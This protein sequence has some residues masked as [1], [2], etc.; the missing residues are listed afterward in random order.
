M[1]KLKN[2]VNEIRTGSI[3]VGKKSIETPCFFATSDFGGGGTNVS[4]LLVYSDLFIKSKSQLLMNYYYLDINSDLT[5]RF[6]TEIIKKLQGFKDINEFIQYVK[7]EYIQA[8]PKK[9]INSYSFDSK[10]KWLPMILLDSGSGNILRGKIKRKEVTHSNYKIE[11]QKLILNYFNF[12]ISSKFDIIIALDFAAKNT[13][14]AGEMKDKA[15]VDGVLEFS[16][17][18]RN[19]ELLKLTLI[20]MKTNKVMLDVLA[21]VHGNSPKEYEE[22]IQNILKIEKEQ[23]VK[24]SGFAIGGLGNPNKIDK[25]AWSISN[26]T[27]GREKAALYLMQISSIVR[28]VLNQQKDDRLIHILGSASPY[29]LIPLIFSGCDTFDC[30]S[31]WRRASDGNDLSKQCLFDSDKLDQ[32]QDEGYI[33]S[34]S[35]ILVPL[36]DS[37]LKIIPENKDNYLEFE[38]INTYSAKCNCEV[39][40]N[41]SLNNL[42]KAYCGNKEE[43]YYAKILIYLH[44]ILQYD[45]ICDL[46]RTLKSIEELKIFIDSLPD[47]SFK[48]NMKHVLFNQ[49]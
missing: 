24:F 18:E 25:S 33:I 11:Y 17:N 31:A 16:S 22:Y 32:Y 6:D 2:K 29:N 42:Q 10:K 36:L 34:F 47:C 49:R 20:H 13:L 28:S 12:A 37:K 19:F 26:E 46:F 23:G 44:N 14:K 35:K 8:V 3:S 45:Y 15:Y 41:M 27:N 9:A 5:P 43:N 1:F 4:R 21:P 39:C 48:N 38:D 30:H 40:K 7:K